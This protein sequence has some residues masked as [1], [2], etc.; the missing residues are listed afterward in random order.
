MGLVSLFSESRSLW[1]A[2][3]F[4][5]PRN[6]SRASQLNSVAAFSWMIEEAYKHLLALQYATGGQYQKKQTQLLMWTKCIS[7]TVNYFSSSGMSSS[8]ILNMTT[9]CLTQLS[10][11]LTLN[12]N[13][14]LYSR[15]RVGSSQT[16]TH[17][18]THK[19]ILIMHACL[20]DFLCTLLGF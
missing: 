15:L 4:L 6:I 10:P 8:L 18:H 13:R 17:R 3:V 11:N 16:H 9:I 5:R 20:C 12:L 2:T 7:Y 1:A 14:F 19:H